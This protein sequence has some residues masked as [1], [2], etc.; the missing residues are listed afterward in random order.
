[1]GILSGQ[2][3]HAIDAAYAEEEKS[4][5]L[6]DLLLFDVDAFCAVDLSIKVCERC[7]FERR[8]PP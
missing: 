4:A 3:C 6:P 5:T 1:M 2:M 7:R 8:S